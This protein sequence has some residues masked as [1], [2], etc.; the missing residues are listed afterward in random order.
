MILRAQSQWFIAPLSVLQS[1]WKII[2][3]IAVQERVCQVITLIPNFNL[4][5]LLI[6][7]IAWSITP[8]SANPS[9]NGS[10]TIALSSRETLGSVP[11][12]TTFTPQRPKQEEKHTG[13][14]NYR[15][16]LM[17][18][19]LIP[20]YNSETLDCGGRSMAAADLDGYLRILESE[21]VYNK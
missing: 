5:H 3:H 6:T 14:W 4:G 1:V 8:A 19:W 20:N 13:N 11:S 7:C 15:W 17:C 12:A 10:P 16:K 2:L 18:N 21:F 9:T